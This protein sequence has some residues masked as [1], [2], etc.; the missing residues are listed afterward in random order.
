MRLRKFYVKSYRSI[1]E[2]TLDDIQPYCVIVGPNNAG[3][4]NLLH[5]ILN[6][7]NFWQSKGDIYRVDLKRRRTSFLNIG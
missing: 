2:A 5:A 4:P 3:K 6:K 7:F 1:V